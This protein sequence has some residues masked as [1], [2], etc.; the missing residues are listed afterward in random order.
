MAVASRE[1]HEDR[2][3]RETREPRS[4]R[5]LTRETSSCHQRDIHTL[6]GPM[7]GKRAS[8]STHP[9]KTHPR[10]PCTRVQHDSSTCTRFFHGRS[11]GRIDQ[12]SLFKRFSPRRP[13]PPSTFYRVLEQRFPSFFAITRTRFF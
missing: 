4:H 10:V 6:L 9:R 12:H 5:V 13:L 7:A 11:G 3:R 8:R 1:Q 2:W